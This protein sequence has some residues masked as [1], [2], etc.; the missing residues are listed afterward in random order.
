VPFNAA[1]LAR[2]PAPRNAARTLPTPEQAKTLLA[3]AGQRD[4]EFELFARLGAATGLRRGEVV[5]LRWRDL[6]LDGAELHVSGNVLF[7]PGLAGGFVRKEPKSENSERLVALDARTVELLR[8]HRARRAEAALAAGVALA[9]DSYLFTRVVDGA[10]PIR[11][12]AMTRRFNRLAAHLG[13]D[14]T[15]HGLRHFMATQLGAVAEAATVRARMGH[16]SLAVSSVYT[17]RV[18]AADRAAAEHMGRVL[19]EQ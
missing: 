7:L 13:H 14:Y 5:A 1:V 2:P 18:S 17:H 4:P 15:L 16:G 8:A 3:A 6:D 10:R 11:P 12:D 19:D 9:E